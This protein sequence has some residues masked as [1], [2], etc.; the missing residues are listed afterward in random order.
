MKKCIK[1]SKDVI[2][3]QEHGAGMYINIF[4]DCCLFYRSFI[5]TLRENVQIKDIFT[6][7]EK[8]FPWDSRRISHS[9]NVSSCISRLRIH[10]CLQRPIINMS[11]NR[12]PAS[13]LKRERT[14]T[15]N[16]RT[17][18]PKSRALINNKRRYWHRLML[19][20]QRRNINLLQAG[21]TRT[22]L[23]I[24]SWLNFLRDNTTTSKAASRAALAGSKRSAL[25]NRA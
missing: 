10:N 15:K 4:Q 19:V 6:V 1:S 18:L 22:Q 5:G 14:E 21:N 23:Y 24:H 9:S 11:N 12:P 20:P 25:K 13:T 16:W 2:I 7:S 17:V 8:V 3:I